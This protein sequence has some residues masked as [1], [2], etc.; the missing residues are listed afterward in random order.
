MWLFLLEWRLSKGV[1]ENMTCPQCSSSNV[2]E[3]FWGFPGNMD[4]IKEDLRNG[5]I[6]LGGCVVTDHDPKLQCNV[7]HHRWGDREDLS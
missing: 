2:A 7:C 5:R 4:E 3:I 6:I 1:L